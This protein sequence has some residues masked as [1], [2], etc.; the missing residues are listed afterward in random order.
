MNLS[1]ERL[2]DAKLVF[3]LTLF[4][5]II[6]GFVWGSFFQKSEYFIVFLIGWMGVAI[7]LVLSFFIL[8][9]L[10]IWAWDEV[11]NFKYDRAEI[12]KAIARYCDDK[13]KKEATTAK[14]LVK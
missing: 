10:V 3:V 8:F 14:D 6:L 7:M 5:G 13:K 11:L 2:F 12:H 9:F 1:F 4:V